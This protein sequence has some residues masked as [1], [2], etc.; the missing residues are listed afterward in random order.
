MNDNDKTRI[1]RL[2]IAEGILLACIKTGAARYDGSMPRK[3]WM[4]G[5]S[6]ES[7]EWADAMIRADA[8]MFPSDT[9]PASAG[10]G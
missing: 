9:K 3:E 7:L 1:M 5:W 8:E 2:G 4:D 10:E 6:R